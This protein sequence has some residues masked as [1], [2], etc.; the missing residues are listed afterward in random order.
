MAALSSPAAF[1]GRRLESSSTAQAHSSKKDQVRVPRKRGCSN[2]IAAKKDASER[3]PS[4]SGK[5]PKWELFGGAAAVLG[6]SSI[7]AFGLSKLGF[8]SGSSDFGNPEIGSGGS[9][10]ARNSGRGGGRGGGG[11]GS[12]GNE[13]TLHRPVL[14]ENKEEDSKE[15]RGKGLVE[16]VASSV[17]EQLSR[18]D[19]LAKA[20]ET[21]ALKRLQKE[22]FTDIMKLRE[23]FEK[24]ELGL[25]TKDFS[26]GL[27]RTTIKGRVAAG[28]AFVLMQDSSSYNSR[29]AL[30]QSGLP[31]GLEAEFTFQTAFRDD[32]DLLT[33]KCVS[34]DGGF[35]TSGLGGPIRLAKISYATKVTDETKFSLVPLGAQATDMT[36]VV[37][38]LQG[39]AL[40]KFTSSGPSLFSHCKGSA[41]GATYRSSN[42][43]A[44]LSE[45]ISG[46]GDSNGLL[47]LSTL[48]QFIHQ[49]TEQL[50]LSL[51][52]LNRF[53]PSPPLPSATG[54]HW[55]EMK[56]FVLSKSLR[57]SGVDTMRTSG[58]SSVS[59]ALSNGDR[60]SLEAPA[61]E[62]K[63]TA[64]Q[65]FAMSGE[66]DLGGGACLGGW[67]QMERG[68]WLQ[69]D[70]QKKLVWS[71]SLAQEASVD[72]VGWGVSLGRSRRDFWSS[73]KDEESDVIGRQAEVSSTQFQVEAFLKYD[74]G[75]RFTLQPGLLYVLNKQ[76]QTPALMVKGEW[77][78]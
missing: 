77:K 13:A 44:S 28:G 38:P 72:S 35:G 17:I 50:A 14:G 11:G 53:W 76:C 19:N 65:A 69:D 3:F 10:G 40:T 2:G 16:E 63:G 55:S 70:D 18:S 37:N 61:Y 26:S 12:R 4:R 45:Y 20:S 51:S 48:A 1:R 57:S 7:A 56:P 43:L 41:I 8:G 29:S 32:N 52:A 23:K 22:A 58:S 33:T 46:W 25:S 5:R 34:G 31:A 75:Q 9:G 66:M 74:F 71:L 27:E 15:E 49:P 78:L 68:D 24:L 59:Q 47:C 64:M 6:G 62:P 54:L 67:L 42:T 39:E 60:W 21:G 36:E 73:L 30:E